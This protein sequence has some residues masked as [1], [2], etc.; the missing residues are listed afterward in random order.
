MIN[1]NYIDGIWNELIAGQTR[2]GIKM[3]TKLKNILF[4]LDITQNGIKRYSIQIN[5]SSFEKPDFEQYKFFTLDFVDLDTS[6]HE[7]RCELN[8]NKYSE[9]FNYLII[10]LTKK[11]STIESVGEIINQVKNQFNR[12]SK[13]FDS[14]KEKGMPVGLQTG[15][16]GELWFLKEK[17]IPYSGIIKSM[18]AYRGSEGRQDFQFSNCLIEIKSSTSTRSYFMK[19]ANE[20]QLDP[21][22]ELDLFLTY[23]NMDKAAGSGQTLTSI[24]NEIKSLCEQSGNDIL[25]R[26]EDL[27]IDAKYNI[28]KPEQCDEIGFSMREIRYFHVKDNFPRI[29]SA[30]LLEGVSSVG[31]SIDVSACMKYEVEETELISLIDER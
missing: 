11:I 10:H 3:Q 27:L 24:V 6:R 15:L 13:F 2:Q 26:F 31:Y 22:N 4:F 23:I 14:Y 8:D 9:E 21:I 7:I 29:K 1:E 18:E 19:I 16:Y 20:K 12:W 25:S 5:N 30:D 28:A 17:I